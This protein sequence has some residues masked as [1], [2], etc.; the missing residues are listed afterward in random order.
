[1]IRMPDLDDR[2]D[3]TD[4]DEEYAWDFD[5]VYAFGEVDDDE[6]DEED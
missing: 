3:E 4:P 1:M 5:N 2:V 6:E